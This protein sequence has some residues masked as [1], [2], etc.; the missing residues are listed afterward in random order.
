MPVVVYAANG[1][2]GNGLL[3]PA[4]IIISNDQLNQWFSTRYFVFIRF[5]YVPHLIIKT[6]KMLLHCH[7]YHNC[8]Y[9]DMYSLSFFLSLLKI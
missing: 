7:E 6:V 1:P 2:F 4:F 9:L 5:K 3:H 8:N